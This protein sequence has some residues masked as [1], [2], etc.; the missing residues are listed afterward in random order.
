MNSAGIQPK[1]AFSFRMTLSTENV[2]IFF[3][4]RHLV[5]DTKSG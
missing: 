4:Y 2:P 3:Q 5:I 1:R